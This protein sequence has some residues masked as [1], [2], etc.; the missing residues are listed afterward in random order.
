MP[1][2]TEATSSFAFDI[3]SP[4]H[5]HENQFPTLYDLCKIDL[6]NGRTDASSLV[7]LA[8]GERDLWP[9]LIFELETSRVPD[10]IH[11]SRIENE[12][13]LF[14]QNEEILSLSLSLWIESQR[15]EEAE[16]V[17]VGPSWRN[18]KGTLHYDELVDR[19]ERIVA[20][21]INNRLEW[22]FDRTEGRELE[23]YA[24]TISSFVGGVW[25]RVASHD[26]E[27]DNDN[28]NGNGGGGGGSEEKS[29]KEGK[30]RRVV[31]RVHRSTRE[32]ISPEELGVRFARLF[33]PR[34]SP[35]LILPVPFFLS[36]FL[37]LFRARRERSSVSPPCSTIEPAT[38]ALVHL[39][40][41]V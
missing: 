19:V 10:A 5:S 40:V 20:A 14:L 28:D 41:M 29:K 8:K 11:R 1:R 25:P 2:E 24:T 27:N 21:S 12:L 32:L 4:L 13:L 26:N 39:L 33:A 3:R 30:T 31:G 35:L 34:F 18:F 16:N 15:D 38:H 22:V 7:T 23:N 9:S 37:S 17:Y 6:P 36:F